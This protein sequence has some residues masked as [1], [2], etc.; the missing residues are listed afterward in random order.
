MWMAGRLVDQHHAAVG[1]PVE[2]GVV[3]GTGDKPVLAAAQ[4]QRRHIDAVQPMDELRI[5]HERRPAI[6]SLGFRPARQNGQFLVALAVV[7]ERRVARIDE[8]GACAFCRLQHV[9][10]DEIPVLD[11]AD[12]DAVG[13]GQHQPPEACG[14]A[15]SYLAGDP[16][17][18]TGPRE[19]NV[20][21][22]HGLQQIEIEIG[23]IID[24]TEMPWPLVTAEAGMERGD[25]LEACAQQ[26]EVVA[27]VP[28]RP[29][30]RMQEE[31]RTPAAGAQ[32]VGCH[33]AQTQ[34]FQ[35]GLCCHVTLSDPQHVHLCELVPNVDQFGRESRRKRRLC[36]SWR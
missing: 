31:Q 5:M 6:E 36:G 25:H 2:I 22:A 26:A 10:I 8:F 7:G 27:G 29:R 34:A 1:Y 15:H 24:R 9:E 11:P 16:A 33:A 12:L 19:D 21:Q 14:G 17:P 30:A 32:H 28:I 18:E 35:T 23:K 3:I 13:R 4:D 20:F